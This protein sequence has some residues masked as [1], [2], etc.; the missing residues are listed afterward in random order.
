MEIPALMLAGRAQGLAGSSEASTPDDRALRDYRQHIAD[1]RDDIDEATFNNDIERSAKANWEL[2]ILVE[3]L[4]AAA[5]TRGRAR[6]QFTGAD[7]RARMS[8]TSVWCGDQPPG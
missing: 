6:Q 3:Q 5:G 7:E 1:L 8:V 4:T 2:D